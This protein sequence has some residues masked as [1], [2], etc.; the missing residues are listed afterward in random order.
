MTHHEHQADEAEQRY[1][2]EITN[3]MNTVIRTCAQILTRH[4]NGRT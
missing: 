1:R 4:S 3:V 2:A